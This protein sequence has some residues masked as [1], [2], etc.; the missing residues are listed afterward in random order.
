M[1]PIGVRRRR[2]RQGILLW[3]LAWTVGCAPDQDG[4]SLNGTWQFRYDPDGVGIAE[5]W[6]QSTEDWEQTVRVPG[7]WPDEAYDGYGWFKT[8]FVVGRR[9]KD[10]RL[11]LVF[12]SVDDN[13]EVWLNGRHVGTHHGYGERFWLDITDQ[14]EFG[15]NLLVVRIE[16]TGGPG[17]I[18]GAVTMDWYG[19]EKELLVSP[20]SKLE[21]AVPPDWLRTAALYEIFVRDF[22][23]TGDFNGVIARLDA[24]QELGVDCLWLMPIHPVGEV[25]RKGPWGSPYSCADY[26]AVTPDYG[27]LEDFRRLVREAHRRGL[28]VILDMVLNHSAWDNPLVREHPD[29]YTQ[30]TGGEIVAPNNDWTDVADFNYEVPA[31]REYMLDMLR[32]WVAEFDVDGFR[33]DVAEL[34]PLDFWME[35][36]TRLKAVK[37]D[38]L[39]LAEGDLPELHREAFDLTYSWN[40]WHHVIQVC[41]GRK[42]PVELARTLTLETTRYP[43]GSYRM[44]FVENHD[45]QRAAREIPPYALRLAHAFI[46]TIPGV[47]LLYNG[48]EVALD[49]RLELF[50]KDSIRWSQGDRH[51]RRFIARLGRL[52]HGNPDLAGTEWQPLEWNF[53]ESV[54]GWKR[55]AATVCFANFGAESVEFEFPA[56]ATERY[57]VEFTIGNSTLNQVESSRLVVTLQPWD[58]LVARS[59]EDS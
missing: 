34:V 10:R 38:L 22:S 5:Q 3:I 28:R 2:V 59:S 25:R 16:D 29:W 31:L 7:F 56:G 20:L 14:V 9:V 6:Y 45:K 8:R 35:A 49:H 54:I 13:A 11:A 43:R 41:N 19:E 50:V 42:P 36:R 23:P 58:L 4:L 37:P 46:Y 53:P 26:Y 48:E 18:H 21:A 1:F 33:F 27:T 30:N 32:W 12:E 51:F 15:E 47:P 24:L 17:G 40:V 44:R 52:K 39:F 57:S 55:G